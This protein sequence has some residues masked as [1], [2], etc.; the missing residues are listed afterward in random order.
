MRGGGR[1]LW[2]HEPC[3]Q[4]GG[5]RIFPFS[6]VSRETCL[7]VEKRWSKAPVSMGAQRLG[8]TKTRMSRIGCEP[9]R[10][11]PHGAP[12]IPRSRAS[13]PPYTPALF[14]PPGAALI[15]GEGKE[16][17]RNPSFLPSFPQILSGGCDRSQGVRDSL[18]QGCRDNVPGVQG[19]H[20]RV[21]ALEGPRGSC[22]CFPCAVHG[23]D[24]PH[25]LSHPRA[26]S[27]THTIPFRAQEQ[28][29]HPWT[30]RRMHL[31]I[32]QPLLFLS[33]FLSSLPALPLGQDT[34]VTDWNLMM[35]FG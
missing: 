22:H 14:T 13:P 24:S 15:Q 12:H 6:L 31:C 27:C 3:G 1:Q 21:P 35:A 25:K 30:G 23:R 32:S 5:G 29:S 11:S 18:S 4:L 28:C 16:E 33:R 10:V 2:S 8:N 9:S 26:L 34:W 19:C 20:P 17:Q 7:W